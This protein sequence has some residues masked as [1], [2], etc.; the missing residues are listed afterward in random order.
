MYE[1]NAQNSKSPEITI[2]TRDNERKRKNPTMSEKTQ[3]KHAKSNY[4]ALL[5]VDDDFECDQESLSKFAEHLHSQVNTKTNEIKSNSN[6]SSP[7]EQSPSAGTSKNYANGANPQNKAN[8]DQN[9]REKIPPINIYN[10]DPNE[11]ISFI[12]NG[13]KIDDFKI[14]DLN[15]KTKRI[16]LYLN[17]LF[18]YTRVKNH[19]QKTNTNFYTYTPKCLKKKYSSLKRYQLRYKR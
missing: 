4:Y 14:K 1:L 8:N 11:L 19:L 18:N 6:I 3:N 10:V 16:T 5:D 17:T 9:K 2:I 7:I 13:L 12:K 15:H